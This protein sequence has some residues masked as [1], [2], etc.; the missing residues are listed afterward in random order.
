MVTP[1][2]NQVYYVDQYT[3]YDFQNNI[4]RKYRTDDRVEMEV[5]N[6]LDKRCSESKR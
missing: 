3:I 4:N 6:R 1:H 2:L 5:I